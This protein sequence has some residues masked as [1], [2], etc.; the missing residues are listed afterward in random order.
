[1]IVNSVVTSTRDTTVCQSALPFNWNGQSITAAGTYTANLTSASGCD[2][3][4]TLNVIVNSVVTSTTDTTLCQSALPFDWNGQ[5]VTAAGTYIANLTSAAGCDSVATLNVIVNP[6]VTSTTDTTVCQS[7]LPFDWNGQSITAAG[8]YTANL[9]SASGCDSI[10]TLNV[11]INPVVT[12]TTD[13]TVC[14]SA[15][16]FD[17]NGQSITAAGTYTANLTSASGC[18]SI[19]TLNV[20]VNSVVTSTRDTTV[21][22]SALPFDWNGQSI[23]AAGTYTA[24]LTSASGCDS[25][26]TLNVALTAVVT[27]TTDT[28]VCQSAL[29]FDWN[30]QSIAAAGTYTANLTSASGCDS[31]ATLNVI[32]NSVVTGTTDTTVCQSALPFDWNGQSI[33]AAGTYA[34]NLT[35]ASGCDSVATL[36]V[37]VNSVVTSTTDTTVCQSALPFDW[38]GH[39]ITAAGTY[40]ANLTS[41][42]GCDSIATLNVIVNSVVTSTT[43]TTVCQSAL[44]FDW[45][46]HSITAAGTYTANLTSASGC[47]SIATLNVIVNSVVTSTTDIAVCQSALPFDW[48]GQS[49][50]AA[51]KYTANLT[52]ASGCDSIATLNVTIVNVINVDRDTTVCSAGIPF[53]WN[54]ITVEK[55]GDY[56]YTTTSSLGCDSTTTL[57]VTVSSLNLLVS[58]PAATCSPN[59]VDL[60]APGITAGSD[61]G[62]NLTYWTN[63]DATIPLVDPRAIT[64]TGIYYIKATSAS[65]C[66]I[67]KP[68]QVTINTAAPNVVVTD[69][70]AVCEPGTVDLTNPDITSGSDPG[71]NYTYW[72]DAANTV[73]LP[74]PTAVGASGTY[75]ITGTANGGCSSTMS[76]QVVVKVNKATPGMTYPSVSTTANTSIQLNARDLGIGY[77]YKWYPPVGINFNDIQDPTFNYNRQTQYTITLTPPDGSCPT[78]DTLLVK[79][80]QDGPE[81][82]SSLH[83]P[84]AWSPNGDGHNDRLYPLTINMKEL[85]YFRV[86]DRWGQLMFQT[87]ILGV[88]WDGTFNGQPQVMDVYT[89]TV[90]A[91]GLDGVHYKLAGNSILMR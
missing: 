22:Q 68:V 8:T 83:V 36:N 7:A 56:P 31:V 91:T 87:S 77:T 73:P 12:S 55:A 43:D 27:S 74:D 35:S 81:L 70:A 9:T 86:Y 76:V 2:S 90:E 15:L 1:V 79:I 34:A 53:N 20:I 50:T 52:S 16:P 51:G 25:V 61:Q 41:A 84:N 37:V 67:I 71:L 3:V 23:T 66:S 63:S 21:C 29:P 30:D 59:T 89:W 42:S 13:T 65:V 39:S 4:A 11:T 82:K 58:D 57:H 46:G 10:A 33:T 54:G 26:A 18:D 85:K 38:N 72:M 19:A 47:D 44:P 69:P 5:S 32:V 60:T 40:T 6:I 49:I 17:W 80:V 75:Y 88:G 28:T 64:T 24:N 62:L 14:Q 48:N 78:V 45:N